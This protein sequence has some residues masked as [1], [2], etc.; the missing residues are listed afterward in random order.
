LVT[1]A[2]LD[3]LGAV[4][5]RV[6]RRPNISVSAGVKIRQD[7]AIGG[8]ISIASRSRWTVD[9]C[10]IKQVS[11]LGHFRDARDG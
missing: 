8:V 5:G 3:H 10:E 4:L 11:A 1:F 2:A 9:G 6:I 7:A